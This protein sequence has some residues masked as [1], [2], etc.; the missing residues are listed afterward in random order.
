MQTSASTGAPG[1]AGASTLAA[2]G[3]ARKQQPTSPQGTLSGSRT[4]ADAQNA[5]RNSDATKSELVEYV[6]TH[7]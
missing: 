6:C 5:A 3:F 1:G 7:F 4:S 2:D